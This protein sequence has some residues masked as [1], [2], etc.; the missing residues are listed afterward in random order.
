MGRGFAQ[1]LAPTHEVVVGS[2]GSARAAATASKT[3]AAGSGTYAD[4]AANADVVIL[5]VPWKAMDETLGQLG[6]LSGTVVI[7]VSYPA[8]QAPGDH[9]RSR[10]QRVLR[11]R[12]R[13]RRVRER[14]GDRPSPS[15][16]NAAARNGGRS[17]ARQ[18]PAVATGR[19]SLAHSGNPS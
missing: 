3:G 9:G 4:A 2:R 13:K 18:M 19:P 8:R 11:L 1:V 12:R 17:S 5:T 10:G 6:D 15:G 7:D 16:T 14:H